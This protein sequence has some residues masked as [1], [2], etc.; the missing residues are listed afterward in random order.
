MRIY[1]WYLVCY[2]TSCMLIY[3]WYIVFYNNDIIHTTYRTYVVLHLL[4]V[5]SN[6]CYIV[7]ITY[8]VS[9]IPRIIYRAS[10]IPHIALHIWYL[11]CTSITYRTFYDRVTYCTSYYSTYCTYVYTSYHIVYI[12]YLL[13]HIIGRIW[14]H[15][16]IYRTV[17]EW[18]HISYLHTCL[19][20]EVSYYTYLLSHFV[21]TSPRW[22]RSRSRWCGWTGRRTSLL[23]AL[24]G[25]C[26]CSLLPSGKLLALTAVGLLAVTVDWIYWLLH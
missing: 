5:S 12:S 18:Y 8:V 23:E 19:Y 3:T 11:I 21:Y 26:S 16:I 10:Y 4:L 25:S 13:S 6:C 9:Y 1:V 2:L 14:D 17:Y 20:F 7:H 15:R 22:P 24:A